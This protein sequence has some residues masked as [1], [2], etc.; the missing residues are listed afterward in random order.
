MDSRYEVLLRRLERA[1]GAL[2]EMADRYA[3]YKQ[4]HAWKHAR[5]ACGAWQKAVGIAYDAVGSLET[6]DVDP[7]ADELARLSSALI[8]MRELGKI[9][10]S[11]LFDSPH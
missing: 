3:L 9:T 7:S 6:L 11:L 8:Q 2:Q 1:V 4:H 10:N 5:D